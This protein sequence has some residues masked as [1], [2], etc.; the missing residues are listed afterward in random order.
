MKIPYFKIKTTVMV[1]YEIRRVRNTNI[2]F[3]TIFCLFTQCQCHIRKVIVIILSPD[4]IAWQYKI[5]R[6]VAAI[7]N[8]QNWKTL[9]VIYAVIES[10]YFSIE[11]FMDKYSVTKLV[12]SADRR[13]FCAILIFKTKN[14]I[15]ANGRIA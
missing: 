7:Y 12:C 4:R 5:H 14:S 9:I 11:I 10:S 2:I 3:S 15:S 13:I 8:F 6:N 1:F